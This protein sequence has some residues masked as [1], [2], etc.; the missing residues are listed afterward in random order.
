MESTRHRL[1]T[2]QRRCEKVDLKKLKQNGGLFD[3][4]EP[5][6]FFPF[7]SVIKIPN[8]SQQQQGE[9]V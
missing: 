7:D 8:S 4:N 3:S 6:V 9:T 1:Q 5:S 2:S